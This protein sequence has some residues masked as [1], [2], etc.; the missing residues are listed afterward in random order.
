MSSIKIIIAS[1][2]SHITIYDGFLCKGPEDGH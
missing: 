1:Q 2:A